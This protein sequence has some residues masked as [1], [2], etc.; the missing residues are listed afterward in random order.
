MTPTSLRGGARGRV[1]FPAGTLGL[2][3]SQRFSSRVPSQA[4]EPNESKAMTDEQEKEADQ[5]RRIETQI[6]LLRMRNKLEVQMGAI[7][8]ELRRLAE[9]ARRAAR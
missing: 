5:R 1:G 3:G 4:R 9:E 8:D 6:E 2:G 7:D